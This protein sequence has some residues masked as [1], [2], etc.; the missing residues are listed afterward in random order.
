MKPLLIFD[1]DCHFCRGWIMRWRIQTGDGVDYEPFQKAAERFPGIP[2]ENF[3]K[4]VQLITPEGPV[5]SGAEAVFRA[6]AYAPGRGWPL[7]A[8]L[9]IPGL[10]A[11]GDAAYEFVAR[12]RVLFSKLTQLLWGRHLE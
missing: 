1:G 2:R 11:A 3:E 12:H 10:K 7:W 9:N 5:Y 4:A 6:L 8:Y